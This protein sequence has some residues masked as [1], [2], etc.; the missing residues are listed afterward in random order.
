MS[1]FKYAESD[2]KPGL[3]ILPHLLQLQTEVPVVPGPYACTNCG[4]VQQFGGTEQK[5][6][7]Q[8]CGKHRWVKAIPF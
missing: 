8:R 4:H 3:P 7:C 6:G 2:T 5:P 1:V